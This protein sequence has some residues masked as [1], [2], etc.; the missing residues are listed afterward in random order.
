MIALKFNL[1]VVVNL[2]LG[3]LYMIL[4]YEE[5]KIVERSVCEGPLTFASRIY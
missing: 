1:A 4:F 5:K 3:S 2:I